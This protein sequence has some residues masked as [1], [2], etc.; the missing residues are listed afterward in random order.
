MKT[1]LDY[2]LEYINKGISI[3]PVWSPVMLKNNPPGYYADTI[4]KELAK[5]RELENDLRS[6]HQGIGHWKKG[7]G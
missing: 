1:N 3:F 7:T 6:L 5:N 4:K 2:A